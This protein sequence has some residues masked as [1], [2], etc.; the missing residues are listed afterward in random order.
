MR[1]AGVTG[2]DSL[3]G[4]NTESSSSTTICGERSKRPLKATG[5][6]ERLAFLKHRLRLYLEAEEKIL[7][8]KS[9]T[10]DN[11]TLTR[12]SLAEVRKAINDLL[13][14]IAFLEGTKFGN[15]RRVV[16]ID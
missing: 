10:L 15:R 16:F 7:Q 4:G 11:R 3:E 9:Y 13:E 8:A 5:H 1:A 2:V 14:E 12:E 6:L